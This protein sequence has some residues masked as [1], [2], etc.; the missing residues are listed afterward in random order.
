MSANTKKFIIRDYMGRMGE[1]QD[2]L[3]LSIRGVPASDNNRM[4]L[5]LGQKSIRVTVVRNNLARHALKD[6]PL[7]PLGD[8]FAG[9]TALAYG[10]TSVVDVAREIV[11]WAEQLQQLELRGAILDGEVFEGK[12]GVKRLATFPTRVEAQA[13]VVSLV[14]SPAQKVV[15]AAKG[16]GS[17][18]LGIVKT[19]EEKLEKGE[20]I[21][22]IG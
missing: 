3:V 10:G 19:I 1:A 5:A 17:K 22:K 2:A 9:P 18:V 13:K 14:L 15:G 16:P 12:A 21:A 20:A 8:L 11:K 6:T 7:G 4:R